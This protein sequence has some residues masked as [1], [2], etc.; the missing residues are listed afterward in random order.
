[1]GRLYGLDALRGIAALIVVL[2]HLRMMYDLPLGILA[3]SHLAVDFFFMLSGYVMARSYETDGGFKLS[4]FRFLARR[5]RRLWPPMALGAALAMLRFAGDPASLMSVAPLF[6]LLPNVWMWNDG[7]RLF[8][9]NGPAWSITAEL[10]A[11]ALHPLVFAR[12]NPWAL[13]AFAVAVVALVQPISPGLGSY[14]F[15]MPY[16]APIRAI[17]GYCVGIAI[18]RLR[19]ELPLLSPWFGVA[20]LPGSIFVL[21]L[22]SVPILDLAFFALCPLVVMSGFGRDVTR[23][24]PVLGALSFPLYAVHYPIVRMVQMLGGHPALAFAMAILGGFAAMLLTDRAL[25]RRR[26]YAGTPAS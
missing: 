26:D 5:Y 9:G 6:L 20:A 21:S 8:P 18:W 7:Y 3:R 25:F 23:I 12:M 4:T 24:G 1:M 19:G 22:L 2:L 10:I 11:N 15:E 14:L 16:K 13:V 17:C